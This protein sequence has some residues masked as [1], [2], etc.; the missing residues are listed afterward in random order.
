MG[1]RV[2]DRESQNELLVARQER[3]TFILGEGNILQVED[4][5]KSRGSV[6]FFFFFFKSHEC[7]PFH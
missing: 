6:S 7:L 1:V 5:L 2:W 3:G 4:I